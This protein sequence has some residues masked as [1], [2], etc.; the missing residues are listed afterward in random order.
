MQRTP[1]K[2]TQR[3]KSLA[4]GRFF[5]RRFSEQIACLKLLLN[6]VMNTGQRQQRGPDGNRLNRLL[7]AVWL[8]AA[9]GR[10]LD[11]Q[12]YPG[13][14]VVD[15]ESVLALPV[16][17]QRLSMIAGKHNQ[18]G[19]VQVSCAQPTDQTSQFMVGVRDLSIVWPIPVLAPKGLRRIV[20]TV[21]IIEMQPEKERAFSRVLQ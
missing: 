8:N 16:F 2:R 20:G 15:E 10:R 11:D 13:S 1:S 19:I 4:V 7:H 3:I 5:G 9:S 6:P 21:G 14:R 17:T 18:R 12:R